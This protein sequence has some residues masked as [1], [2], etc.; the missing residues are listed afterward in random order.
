MSNNK[1]YFALM[2]LFISL[3]L[4][5]LYPVIPIQ[6]IKICNDRYLIDPIMKGIYVPPAQNSHRTNSFAWK[7]LLN[8]NN[9]PGLLPGPVVG[10]QLGLENNPELSL[11]TPIKAPLVDNINFT[12]KNKNIIKK[13]PFFNTMP[14]S[15]Y[16]KYRFYECNP[17]NGNYCQC[18]NNYFPMYPVGMCQLNGWNENV[19]KCK[20]RVK[21]SIV[22]MNHLLN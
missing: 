8:D 20:Y 14:A 19:C 17:Y 2:F 21:P 15:L 22:Y 7:Y 3:C 12:S 4:F 1:I 6:N 11:S 10:E 5:N 9:I 16:Y 18:T 13:N